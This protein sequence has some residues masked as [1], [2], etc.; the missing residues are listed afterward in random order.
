M[1][2]SNLSVNICLKSVGVTLNC[3]NCQF[4]HQPYILE[5]QLLFLLG[6]EF[7]IGITKWTNESGACAVASAFPEYPC[8]PIKVENNLIMIIL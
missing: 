1:S 5:I 6:R 8:T 2:L 7:F 4:C 3:L